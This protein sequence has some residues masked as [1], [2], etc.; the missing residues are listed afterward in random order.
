MKA[1]GLFEGFGVEIE[2]MIVDAKSLAIRPF[3]EKILTNDQGEVEDEMPMGKA[4]ASNELAAHVIEFKTDGPAKGF[5]GMME[6]FRSAV[7]IAEEKIRPLGLKLLGT[8]MH[9]LMDPAEAVLWPYGQKEIYKAYN[10][11][12]DCRG[13]GW[14]NLQS[15]HLNLPFNDTESFGRLHAAVRCVLPLIPALCAST[16][17]MDGKITGLCDT[18]LSVYR[19]NQKRIPEIVGDVIPEAVFTPKDYEGVILQP[20]YR[21]IAPLDTDH[22]LQEEW[23]NSRGAIVRFDRSAIEIRLVDTQEC[24]EADVAVIA[25]IA[26]AVRGFV[27]ER[28]AP[29]EAQKKVSAKVLAKLLD[30]CIFFGEEAFVDGEFFSEI[31]GG[32][33]GKK[34]GEIWKGWYKKLR[35]V[36]SE[37]LPVATVLEEILSAGT[38]SSRIR[39]A[40]GG[41][42]SQRRIFDVYQNLCR[43]LE[44]GKVF[45]PE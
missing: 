17:L 42:P 3:A 18:R 30:Q 36:S 9:P 37:L 7:D 8:G 35:D 45:I 40:L 28:L 25:M 6:T 44:E 14:V 2:L 27:E 31:Y 5:S 41:N 38:L 23:L 34:A 32:F 19:E 12:F 21:A 43:H 29:F 11:I 24:V 1:L 22:I 10:Q 16:P 39:K 20:M 33:A 15:V 26:A 4:L 13:H